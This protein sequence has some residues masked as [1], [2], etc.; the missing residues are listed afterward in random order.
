MNKHFKVLIAIGITCL[1]F[2]SSIS[3]AY[4]DVPK[5]HPAYDAIMNLSNDG[6]INGVSNDQFAPDVTI[7]RAMLVTVLY[8]IAGMPEPQNYNMPFKDVKDTDWYGVPVLW[9]SQ[10][11]IV[12]G[13]SADEFKPNMKLTKEQFIT[14]LYRY[15]LSM[16][17]PDDSVYMDVPSVKDIETVSSYAV[18][19]MCWGYYNL[20]YKQTDRMSPKSKVSRAD[21]AEILMA[22]NTYVNTMK[23]S[24]GEFSPVGI[25]TTDVLPTSSYT[26][27]ETM[28]LFK[29]NTF[30]TD[31]T[32]VF[33]LNLKDSSAKVYVAGDWSQSDG[34]INLMAT[35]VLT[36]DYFNSKSKFNTTEYSKNI[37]I[38]AAVLFN[39]YILLET[40]NGSENNSF[41]GKYELTG[42]SA[43]CGYLIIKNSTRNY[44]LVGGEFVNNFGG[45]NMGTLNDIA[46]IRDTNKAFI[47]GKTYYRTKASL[48]GVIDIQRDKNGELDIVL[49]ND[50]IDLGFG[51]GVTMN[52]HYKLENKK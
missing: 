10:N 5:G 50:D 26:E 9:A 39:D 47:V 22:F 35:H 38:D 17:Y 36:L 24:S 42:D 27:V 21:L 16:G 30:I 7:N 32:E 14:V 3:Y 4:T 52:G 40:P 49:T 33:K 51:H 46:F 37:T 8:R 1:L 45:Y 43:R 19:A 15:Y 2:F 48:A 13:Y 44:I 18:D 41:K 25:W 31:E 12:N 11:D 20:I 34:Q 6:I 29:D 23:Y 28:A